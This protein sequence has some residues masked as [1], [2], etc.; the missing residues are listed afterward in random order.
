MFLPIVTDADVV[1]PARREPAIP[2]AKTCG[3]VCSFLLRPVRAGSLRP[4]SLHFSAHYVTQLVCDDCGQV[5]NPDNICV[6]CASNTEAV[7]EDRLE[8]MKQHLAE[9]YSP[10]TMHDGNLFVESAI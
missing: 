7:E 6:A 8:A 2:R 1:V 4:L 10:Q 3:D 9:P 5:P